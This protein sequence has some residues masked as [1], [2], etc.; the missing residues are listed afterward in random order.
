[1][2]YTTDNTGP[3]FYE[4]L[5]YEAPKNGITGLGA[6]QGSSDCFYDAI[7]AD[8]ELSKQIVWHLY[9][10]CRKCSVQC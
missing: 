7:A 8:P 10:P 4:I 5:E 2:T 1:M 9:C 6:N 3:I